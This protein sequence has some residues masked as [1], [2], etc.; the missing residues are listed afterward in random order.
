MRKAQR[1]ALEA[2]AKYEALVT[3]SEHKL[4]EANAEVQRL[5]DSYTNEHSTLK[6]KLARY[7]S[8]TSALQQSAAAKDKEVAQMRANCEQ[9][10][11]RLSK[12]GVWRL[13]FCNTVIHILYK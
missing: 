8:T 10:M 9:L 13:T 7:E 11:E 2:R 12:A 5:N 3:H 1:E 6:A 4:S